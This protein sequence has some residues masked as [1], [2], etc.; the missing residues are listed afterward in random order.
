L[1]C[2]SNALPRKL[3]GGP[4][5]CPLNEPSDLLIQANTTNHG[6]IIFCAPIF[7]AISRV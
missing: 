5:S 3:Q 7:R 1:N 4:A 2:R 6:R